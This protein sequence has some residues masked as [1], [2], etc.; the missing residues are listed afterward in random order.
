MDSSSLV[1]AGAP[2]RL[3][4]A[5]KKKKVREEAQHTIKFVNVNFVSSSSSSAQY[6]LQTGIDHEMGRK[7]ERRSDATYFLFDVLI[8]LTVDLQF[9][10]SVKSSPASI[11]SSPGTT[12]G[13]TGLENDPVECT[14]RRKRFVSGESN[15]RRRNESTKNGTHFCFVA[16]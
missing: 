6:D 12:R 7:R 8:D 11:L 13:E 2:R 1:S 5:S 3:L 16:S 10:N 14:F 15:L 4:S 9:L